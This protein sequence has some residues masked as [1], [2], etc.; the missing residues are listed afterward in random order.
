MVEVLQWGRDNNFWTT[1][2]DGGLGKSSNKEKN[3]GE[4][5]TVGNKNHKSR[6]ASD[7]LKIV[8]TNTKNL[9]KM[10]GGGKW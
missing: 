5:V 9:M 10:E 1:N 6:E 4:W 7:E 8:L 3:G 2:I